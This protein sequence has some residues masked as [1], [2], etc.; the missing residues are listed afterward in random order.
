[1]KNSLQNSMSLLFQPLQQ[2]NFIPAGVVNFGSKS[3]SCSKRFLAFSS[4]TTMYV[5]D[6]TNFRLVRIFTTSNSIIRTIQFS[7]KNDNFIA[8]ATNDYVIIYDIVMNDQ[9]SYIYTPHY[10]CTMCWTPNDDIVVGFSVNYDV[11]FFFNSKIEAYNQHFPT[12]IDINEQLY[13]P[14]HAYFNF[15]L[16]PPE[17]VKNEE[18]IHRIQLLFYDT[19]IATSVILKQKTIFILGCEGSQITRIDFDSVKFD[20]FKAGSNCGKIKGIDFDP[21]NSTN[22]L[23][24]WSNGVIILLD[25]S[26]EQMI[27]IHR[28]TINMNLSSAIF[29]SSPPGHFLTGNANNGVLQLYSS[30]SNE[31]IEKISI[32]N[33][34]I[35]CMERASSSIKELRD[36]VVL[37]FIDGS[38]I[39]YDFYK[40]QKIWQN[41]S[42]H[43]N[44]VFDVKLLP[45][46]PDILVSLGAE[47]SV[48][49]WNIDDA[50]PIDRFVDEK[51][52]FICMT[53]THGSGYVI[54]GCQSGSIVVFSVKMLKILYKEKVFDSGSRVRSIDNS[55]HQPNLIVISSEDG[56]IFLYDVEK[57][58]IVWKPSNES[59]MIQNNLLKNEDDDEDED[60]NSFAS[61][62]K[63]KSKQQNEKIIKFHGVAFSPHKDKTFVSACSSGILFVNQDS[64]FYCLFSDDKFD[65][66]SVVWSPHKD[67]IVLTTSDSGRV[68]LWELLDGKKCNTNVITN[69]NGKSRGIT[70]HPS[71]DYIA[72]SSGYDGCI[73]LFNTK[74]FE[75]YCQVSAHSEPTYGLTFSPI[76]PYLLVSSAADTTIRI[77]SFDK[78]FQS[79]DEFLSSIF[80][81][82]YQK[83]PI[84]P[85]EGYEELIGLLIRLDKDKHHQ[86]D[87]DTENNTKNSVTFKEG[88]IPHINDCIRIIKRKIRRMLS[89]APHET[90]MIK[91]AIK[92]KERMLSAAKLALLTGNQKK[93][94]E[95]LFAA[96]EYD[97]ALAVAPSVSYEFWKNLM[98]ERIKLFEDENDKVNYQIITGESSEAIKTILSE[99]NNNQIIKKTDQYYNNAMLIVA[100]QTF[101]ETTFKV[102]QSKSA[103]AKELANKNDTEKDVKY[104]DFI[105]DNNQRLFEYSVASKASMFY[106]VKG[107]VFR[108]ASCFLA[109]GDLNSAIK[110][111]ERNGE[112]MIASFIAN[113]FNLMDKR[114]AIKLMRINPSFVWKNLSPEL[115]SFTFPL[116]SLE[117]QQQNIDHERKKNENDENIATRI[118]NLLIDAN[119]NADDEDSHSRLKKAVSLGIAYLTEN[120][121]NKAWDFAIV[122]DVLNVFE[123]I[124]NDHLSEKNLILL[125]AIDFYVA[126]FDALWKGFNKIVKKLIEVGEFL[127]IKVKSEHEWICD[128]YHNLK[129]SLKNFNSQK[130]CEIAPVGFDLIGNSYI[131][132]Q[133]SSSHSEK[134]SIQ[135]LLMWQEVT[136]FSPT[137][138][139]DRIYYV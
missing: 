14:N 114:M 38:I 46:N 98:K 138:S 129:G 31:P 5:Y 109:V 75:V 134:I 32:G 73:H 122:K 9:V 124:D 68:T 79:T 105:F 80:S 125:N 72:A 51:D 53:I 66:A 52:R 37:N 85:L 23:T 64:S 119:Q 35:R 92:S 29:L 94:C 27:E 10:F 57:K 63:K 130:M 18:K 8:V 82:D 120:L 4:Y 136:S 43:T 112:L 69:H 74:T 128:L 135:E 107:K 132:L 113:N 76:N 137:G 22:C 16:P 24:I 28:V 118:H 78:L 108:A 60:S 101:S 25:L 96:G 26:T 33:C 126:S 54:C 59:I 86:K 95:L 106:L 56:Q 99:D 131:T 50:T 15:N 116:L 19:Y 100:S 103:K 71:L 115:Q 104:C 121:K 77:W 44:T 48:C 102:V 87:D 7:K 67:N 2:I 21:F 58:K 55:P 65:L 13:N 127:A 45:S 41:H 20:Y 70:F 17:N 39:V 30:T 93:Y 89:A 111:L 6:Q 123:L 42:G 3:L 139:C 110:L 91:K 36:S 1:M 90:S 40:K 88:F 83:V 84:R 47:G 62:K 133:D 61:K 12:K 117:D 81:K 34:G 97:K 49:T 11:L